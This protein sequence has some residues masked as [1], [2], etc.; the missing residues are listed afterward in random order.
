[1]ESFPQLQGN[2]F[3]LTAIGERYSTAYDLSREVAPVP[4]GTPNDPSN[5]RYRG[6][7]RVDDYLDVIIPAATSL[8]LEDGRRLTLRTCR[9]ATRR[10]IFVVRT[11]VRAATDTRH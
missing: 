5:V 4:N 9:A 2:G 1:M 7:L 11:G 8:E 3:L 6:V 10:G